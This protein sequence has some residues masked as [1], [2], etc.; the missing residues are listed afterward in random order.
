[1]DFL[2][3]LRTKF[4][5]YRF[6]E[7]SNF[8]DGCGSIGHKHCFNTLSPLRGQSHKCTYCKKLQCTRKLQQNELNLLYNVLQSIRQTDAT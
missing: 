5:S 3:V 2:K 1:M 6:G 4:R 8:C 7:K